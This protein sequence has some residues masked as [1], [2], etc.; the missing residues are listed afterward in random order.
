MITAFSI[1][2][3]GAIVTRLINLAGYHNW[4][5]PHSWG[6]E[7]IEY[8]KILATNTVCFILIMLFLAVIF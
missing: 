5:L 2:G 4:R 6:R 3:L 1:L 7:F 8:F